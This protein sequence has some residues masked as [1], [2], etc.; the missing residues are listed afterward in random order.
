VSALHFDLSKGIITDLEESNDSILVYSSKK[1][2]IC[3]KE[4]LNKI[5]GCEFQE[6]QER[7]IKITNFDE[8]TY[9]FVMSREIHKQWMIHDINN[10][11]QIASVIMNEN[12]EP[13]LYNEGINRIVCIDKS[14]NNAL[15]SITIEL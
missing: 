6:R 13:I 1:I 15:T 5:S 10:N 14:K 8:V 4:S 11:V 2:S 3:K 7:I 9:P 12:I